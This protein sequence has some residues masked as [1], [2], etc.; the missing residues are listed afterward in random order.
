MSPTSRPLLRRVREVVNEELVHLH[1]RLGIALGLIRLIPP[2]VGGRLRVGLLRFAGCR[3]DAGTLIAGEITILGGTQPA[4]NFTVGSACWFNAGSTFDAT[5]A[6]VIGDRVR[7]GPEVLVLTS[8]HHFGD[9]AERAGLVSRAPVSIGSGV[10]LGA[11]VIIL[12][13]VSI[14]DG[15]VVAAGAVVTRPVPADQLV[16]GVPARPIRDLQ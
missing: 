16:A 11:R 13:G 3:I 5:D 10:W 9:H 8:G 1:P 2:F 6:I 15:A 14:G 4:A 7:I 12:P